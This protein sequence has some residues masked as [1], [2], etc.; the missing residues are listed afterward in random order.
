MAWQSPR[1]VPDGFPN[2][3]IFQQLFRVASQVH[4]PILYTHH[5]MVGSAKN[6]N[7][8]ESLS[9]DYPRFFADV[10]ALRQQIRSLLPPET[11]DHNGILRQQGCY[12]CTLSGGDYAFIVAFYAALSIGAA[13]APLGKLGS[14]S[15]SC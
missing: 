4:H 8:R 10:I 9:I 11:L 15:F 1:D 12:I 3:T 14:F 6:A 13:V 5:D 2:D 7:S